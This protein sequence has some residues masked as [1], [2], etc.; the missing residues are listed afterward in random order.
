MERKEEED[1]GLGGFSREMD[2]RTFLK[3]AFLWLN[4]ILSLFFCSGS[5]QSRVDHKEK[6]RQPFSPTSTRQ[7][8]ITTPITTVPMVT[9]SNPTTSTSPV[10]NP[11]STPGGQGSASPALVNPASTASPL[12]LTR[13]WCVASQAASQIALQVALDY[14]CGYGGADCSAIQP[15]G[16]C[17]EPSTV[18][19]HASYAFNDYFQKN[20]VPASC[21]FGGTAVITSTDPSSGACQYASTST[22]SSVLNTTSTSGA[23]VFGTSPPIS[24]SSFSFM[25]VSYA[26][27]FIISTITLP[28]LL[29]HEASLL[30]YPQ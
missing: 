11:S 27:P 12:P 25:H 23:S 13:S 19:D 22:S 18:R 9:P 4:L 2:T 21:N 29:P 7:M 26:L 17:Y 6:Q 20:P 16:S 15:S 8:D 3:S 28:L 5:V 14:A 24:S 1:S 10:M 30:C